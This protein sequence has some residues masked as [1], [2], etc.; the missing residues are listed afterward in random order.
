MTQKLQKL[1]AN[2]LVILDLAQNSHK[3][4][5]LQKEI[6]MQKL[7]SL[8]IIYKNYKHL[9]RAILKIKII[10]KKMARKII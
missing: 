8:K 5:L 10:L 7:L 2:M 1:K 3:Q 4:I 6:L 9:T